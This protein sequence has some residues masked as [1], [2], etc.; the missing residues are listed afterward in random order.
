[1][2]SEPA[3]L[4]PSVFNIPSHVP[5][6]DALAAGVTTLHASG[7]DP[8]AL[9]RVLI[10]LPTRRACRALQDAFLRH[11]GGRAL[12]LPRMVP[13][14]DIDEDALQFDLLAMQSPES[15]REIPPAIGDLRR[16][17]LLA[18]LVQESAART[19]ERQ[20]GEGQLPIDQAVR[21]AGE[22]S[23]LLDQVQTE[24]L[25]FE[26]LAGL[27][28]EDYATH[29]QL[30]LQFLGVLTGAW[31]ERLAAE[32]VID[33]AER[34]NLLL[35]ARAANWQRNPPPT[36]VIAAGSTG[37]IPATADLLAVVA[38][39]PAGAVVLPGLDR[40][41]DDDV[42]DMAEPSHPQFGLR[43]LLAR[44]GVSRDDVEAWPGVP[45][46][47]DR[48][49]AR[50]NLI[51][52]ALRPAPATDSWAD[53]EKLD[54]AALAGLTR[55][56]CAGADEEAGAIALIMREVLT[57]RGRTA[58]LVTPDRGLARRVAGALARWNVVVDDSGGVP[59]A[60]TPPGVFFRLIVEMIGQAAAP[61]PLLSALKHPLAA[62]GL[63]PGGFRSLVRTLEIAVL[64]GPRLAPGLPELAA[65]ARRAAAELE[66][67]ELTAAA[68]MLDAVVVS[69]QP[70]AE[71][72]AGP[73]RPVGEIVEAHARFA[74]TLAASDTLSGADRLWGGDAGENLAA[75][76]TDLVDAGH[77]LG[78][79]S[80]ARYPALLEALFAGR[81][82]RPRFGSHPRLAILGPL[83]ARLQ[84]YD[85]MILGGLNE[86]TWPPAL[87]ADPWMSRPMRADFGLP[88]PERRTGLSAHDFT[89]AMG[90]SEVYLTR[91]LRVDGSPTVPA[92]WLTRLKFAAQ[93]LDLDP[94]EMTA[95]GDN[96]LA[97][98]RALAVVQPDGAPA[99]TISDRGRPRPTP[100]VAARPRRLSVTDIETWM[101]DPYA[102]YARHILK[103][104]ALRPLDQAPDAADYG[105]RI[106]SVLDRFLSQCAPGPL[107]EDALARLVAAGAEMLAPIRALPA[108]WTFW[109]PRF[110]RI[111]E[112][113]I[114][115]ET[116]RR[117]GVAETY[118]EV[119]GR[120]VL[121][122]PQGPFELVARADRVD[123]LTDGK[124]A[125]IDFKTGAVPGMAEVTAGFAPQ[126]PLEAAMAAAG[127]FENV[128]PGS[129][130]D[131]EYWRLSGGRTVGAVSSV[132]GDAPDELAQRAQA[133][134]SRLIETFDDPAT[135]YESRPR[136]NWAPRY[137]DYE[138]LARVKEW[139][140]SG[141]DGDGSG[142]GA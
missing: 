130:G 15:E 91:A 29:W 55:I 13:I 139:S 88:Q 82:V 113:F 124:L 48:Q 98:H 92:R 80:P 137:S 28:P 43:Q 71:M 23:S 72:L 116:A 79:V 84:R 107:P 40:D 97:W 103:L 117:A 32:G 62:G 25:G 47:D 54:A 115:T 134:L 89:Q 114:E 4:A 56:D 70:F 81:T 120:L 126:L 131:L 49:R 75:F 59:L 57:E 38:H 104:R 94:A 125:I 50:A 133:G 42:W 78:P 60:E 36:P 20:T 96:W 66:D 21:L 64:R 17:L 86:G 132:G 18:R 83:E 142:D 135:P 45:P 110:L 127:G 27:V 11:S 69:A 61:Y 37:S 85:V 53:I 14:G 12:L 44:L 58:A 87:A 65:A 138:H 1:M 34:R 99:P 41:L 74:E 106:H 101:R 123:R 90:A 7:D 109:W 141:P 100:P 22:L 35:A 122:G 31:P 105:S 9:A 118:T 95:R 111:A 128:L 16:R 102:I 93:A 67:P 140:V 19:S 51:S 77:V 30:T 26:R 129:V 121:A 52:A 5:F 39:L 108:V 73:V 10:L 112:W 24:R 119:V 136:A 63:S 46:A 2:G 6:V 76:V 33:A 68:D 3:A 8:L